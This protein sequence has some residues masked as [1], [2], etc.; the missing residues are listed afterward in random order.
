MKI[1][2]M[3][4]LNITSSL[5]IY[6]QGRI[7]LN[8]NPFLLI[9]NSAQLVIKNPSTNAIS[10]IGSGGH[11]VSEG[12]NNKIK[13]DIG[14]AID[15]YNI[16]FS[17]KSGNKIPLTLSIS[18]AGIDNGSILFS[19]YGGSTWNNATYLPSDVTSLSSAC[20]SNNSANV[21]DRFW[22]IEPINYTTKP[23]VSLIFTYI[24]SEHTA[25]SNTI[26]ESTLFAQRFNQDS[27]NNWGDW[28]GTFNTANVINNTVSSGL[29]SP[30][31]FFRS[32]TLVNQNAPL[33]IE[34]LYFRGSCDKNSRLFEWSTAS[35]INNDFF[36]IEKSLDAVSWNELKTIPAAGNSVET[37]IYNYKDV[38]DKISTYYRLKQTDYNKEFSYSNIIYLECSTSSKEVNEYPNPTNGNFIV[39][40]NG[41]EKNNEALTLTLSDVIGSLI[42]ERIINVVGQEH[43][44]IYTL[45]NLQQ[46]VYFL[47]IKNSNNLIIKKIIHQ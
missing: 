6:C 5:C 25:T 26:D 14:T 31:N 44:E 19:T 13:W 28:L 16:P 46:G 39:N 11:I 1:I 47:T 27:G 20:C 9:E 40:I 38:E 41:F 32:W 7:I 36:T 21:I 4:I 8:N 30:E 10:Q 17:T 18:S 23:A 2:F 45:S 35:E 34:L 12:E 3:F 15:T 43:K 37:K 22:I 29:V 42:D 24:D 33:P